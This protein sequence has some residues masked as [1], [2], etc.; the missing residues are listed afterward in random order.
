MNK[1]NLIGQQFGR[2]TVISDSGLR[3]KDGCIKWKCRCSCGKIVNVTTT[4]LKNGATQSCG[5]YR[6]EQ[7]YRA[8]KKYNIYKFYD[9]YGIGY[10]TNNK[11]FY[12]DL[13]DYN[14]IKD[15]C[16]IVTNTKVVG[17]FNNKNVSMHTLILD[18]P[19]DTII[20]H[21]NHNPS[22][23]RKNNLRYATKQ[24]NEY[25]RPCNKN[26][27]LGI[28]GVSKLHNGKYFARI[29]H[30]YKNIYLGTF[31]T[32][33]EAKKARQEAEKKYCGEFQYQE[34]GEIIGK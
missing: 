13:E 9:T 29:M 14:K 20:D 2:L 31:S 30:N 6:L 11:P 19:Q 15:I 16:W 7:L 22:D 21:I 27:K 1:S 24:T 32:I 26:N 4:H 28:K 8:R 23:N 18:F 34:G 5:C 3:S 12:F 33:E 10:D 25:N 17:R